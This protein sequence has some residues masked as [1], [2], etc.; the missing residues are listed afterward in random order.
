MTSGSIQ[1]PECG[2]KY[3]QGDAGLVE[4]FEMI[5]ENGMCVGC[6]QDAD[7]HAEDFEVDY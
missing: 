5:E 3:S 1:C 7:E 6:W 4:E 2:T